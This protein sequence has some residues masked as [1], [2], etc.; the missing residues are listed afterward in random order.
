MVTV[1]ILLEDRDESVIDLL[2]LLVLLD[3]LGKAD[4]ELSEGQESESPP[5]SHNSGAGVSLTHTLEEADVEG[6]H[7]GS[8]QLFHVLIKPQVVGSV[9]SQIW[10]VCLNDQQLQA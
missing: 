3:L 2:R 9:S 7:T 4:E 5:A 1:L 10:E 8:A 6:V